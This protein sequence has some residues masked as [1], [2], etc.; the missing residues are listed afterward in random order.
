MAY[1]IGDI[2]N[3][4]TAMGHTGTLNRVR[5]FEYLCERAA[6]TMLMKMKPL[7]LM[8]NA[9][10]AQAVHDSIYDYPL[11]SYFGSVIDVYPVDNRQSLDDASRA[12]AED[13][14]RRAVVDQDKISIESKNGVKFMRINWP[15]NMPVIL[16]TM[17]S[18]TANGT[19]SLIGTTT[20]LKED[21]ERLISGSGSIQ[22]DVAA[23]G[24]GIENT[25]LSNLDLS[26]LDDNGEFF[27]WLWLPATTGLTS[28]SLVFGEDLTT[29]YWTGAAQTKQSDGSAFAAG[30]NLIRTPWN[31]A[32]KT[33][34]PDD[35]KITAAKITLSVTQAIAG[36]H[37]D[38][39]IVSKGRYFDI[40]A[41]SKWLFQ[42]TSGNWEVRPTANSD[43][44]NVMLD[45]D[46][47]QIFLLE[48]LIGMAQQLEATDGEF[49]IMFAKKELN[50]DPTSPTLEGRMGLYRMYKS[51]QPDQRKKV[52]TGYMASNGNVSR[53]RW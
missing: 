45:A 14:A 5:N 10:L 12:Y 20:N 29:K 7:E 32:T 38:N 33:G 11:Q 24:D 47:L 3:H 52:T 25:G 17:D 21:T 8:Y 44:D 37:V 1:T 13:F 41:Y 40:K 16:N 28:V 39:I 26:A 9:E 31:T 53:G 2:K 36:V 46:A 49:D 35:T 15:V 48:L 4:L 43:D 6:N 30:W 51:D 42:D 50:G 23:A 27:F 19:W 34:S 22:F 18:L